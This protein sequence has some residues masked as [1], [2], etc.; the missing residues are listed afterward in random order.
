[1]KITLWL[2]QS[3]GCCV[4]ISWNTQ[5]KAFRETNYTALTRMVFFVMALLIAWTRHNKECIKLNSQCTL[6]PGLCRWG[7][8]LVR[9]TV[10]F[11]GKDSLL[12][13]RVSLHPGVYSK[14]L[15]TKCWNWQNLQWREGGVSRMVNL[16]GMTYNLS[17][18]C[19][20]R[21]VWFANARRSN[22]QKCRLL[23]YVKTWITFNKIK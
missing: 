20:T 5:K 7:S 1:M 6:H 2:Y 12:S 8:S 22:T 17:L 16:Q 14:W 15:L 9:G 18:T 23:S 21:F 4:P 13:F 11:L 10:V 3:A 19:S